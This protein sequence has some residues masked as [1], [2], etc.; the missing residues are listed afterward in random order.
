MSDNVSEYVVEEPIGY[1]INSEDWLKEVLMEAPFNL[2]SNLKSP[3]AIWAMENWARNK[4]ILG[5]FNEKNVNLLLNATNELITQPDIKGLEWVINGWQKYF[6]QTKNDLTII[7]DDDSDSTIKSDGY[8][9]NEI[10]SLKRARKTIKIKAKKPV[11]IT[12][13]DKL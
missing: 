4:S 3:A 13:L 7:S 12:Y 8:N 6:D 2:D 9:N 1:D 5:T 11:I 10:D